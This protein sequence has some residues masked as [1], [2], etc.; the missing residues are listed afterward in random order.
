VK[1]TL[2]CLSCGNIS[3]KFEPYSYISL[4]VPNVPEVYLE[5]CI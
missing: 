2:K 4:P 3:H 5:D 1:T